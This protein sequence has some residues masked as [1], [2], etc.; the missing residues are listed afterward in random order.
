MT[1]NPESKPFP[2]INVFNPQREKFLSEMQR[3]WP[4][5]YRAV[6]ATRYE[7]PAY[8][9]ADYPH[10]AHAFG[11]DLSAVS[12]NALVNAILL[13]QGQ[14]ERLSDEDREAFCASFYAVMAWI[15]QGKISLFVEQELAEALLRTDLPSDFSP[16][17]ISWKWN[18]FRLFLP[19]GLFRVE[20][21]Y[22][23]I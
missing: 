11:H 6:C 16:E 17:D 4:R 19:K 22:G 7:L 5:L 14:G 10:Y 1:E 20:S 3:H 13:A 18:A 15:A 21:E 2:D 23:L 12:L 8:R 9:Q